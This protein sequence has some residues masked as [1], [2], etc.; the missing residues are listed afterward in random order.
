MKSPFKTR[1]CRAIQLM[2]IGILYVYIYRYNKKIDAIGVQL[3]L[4][5]V[6]NVF[7]IYKPSVVISFEKKFRFSAMTY[8]NKKNRYHAYKT[9][10]NQTGFNF[11][12]FFLHS[13]HDSSKWILMYAHV[14]NDI[15]NVLYRTVFFFNNIR[16]Q[17]FVDHIGTNYTKCENT[18]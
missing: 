3:Q 11:Q 15:Q 13:T 6:I 18:Y 1:S 2:Y 14:N 12:I 10:K 4:V 17:S 16:S 7:E 5:G 8:S 9:I